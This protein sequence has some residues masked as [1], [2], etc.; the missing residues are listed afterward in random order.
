MGMEQCKRH[1]EM[2]GWPGTPCNKCIAEMGEDCVAVLKLDDFHQP[3]I[4][5]Q[6]I[7]EAP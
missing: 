3:V 7:K 2:W 4:Y 6:I 5:E 1:P